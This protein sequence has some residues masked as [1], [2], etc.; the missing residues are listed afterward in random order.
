MYRSAMFKAIEFY[1]RRVVATDESAKLDY[2]AKICKEAV[3]QVIE[4]CEF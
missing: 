2:Y 3:R 4:E 1:Q